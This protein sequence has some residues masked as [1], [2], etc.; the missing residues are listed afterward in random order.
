MSFQEVSK[1]GDESSLI[2]THLSALQGL[3]VENDSKIA[4][5]LVPPAPLCRENRIC[6]GE[7]VAIHILPP[8]VI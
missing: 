3:N 2:A 8:C 1:G 4:I 5:C 6:F 7:K